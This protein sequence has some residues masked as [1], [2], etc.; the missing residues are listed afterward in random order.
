MERVNDIDE[1]EE[2]FLGL[3]D[4][5]GLLFLLE[6][7]LVHVSVLLLAV[8]ELKV[9]VNSLHLL[10][11]AVEL[12]RNDP[13]GP[14]SCDPENKLEEANDYDRP[15]RLEVRLIFPPGRLVNSID[16]ASNRNSYDQHE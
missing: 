14:H 3:L 13:R 15:D 10:R 11:R 5:L 4:E 16:N 8:L 2:V 1:F 6:R 7:L 12:E 9:L